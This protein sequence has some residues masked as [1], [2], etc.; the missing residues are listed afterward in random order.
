MTDVWTS[1]GVIAG[2]GV[3]W[4]TGVTWLDPVIALAVGANILWTGF[5]LIHRSFDGLMD[6]A[7]PEEEQTRLRELIHRTIPGGTTFHALRTRRAGSR[8]FADFHLLVP[9]KMSVQA[10]HDL[11]EAI[12]AAVRGDLAGVEVTIHIE[13]IEEPAA[14]SDNQLAEFEP[15]TEENLPPPAPLPETGR[16]ER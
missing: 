3:V 4:L 1:V 6:R 11:A 16:A 2:L 10:A 15:G 14:W 5:V 13:P 7:W 8:R 9:G 12:E